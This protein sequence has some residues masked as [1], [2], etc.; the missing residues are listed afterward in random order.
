MAPAKLF[1]SNIYL[2]GKKAFLLVDIKQSCDIDTFWNLDIYFM[3]LLGLLLSLIL[4]HH[5]L[6]FPSKNLK[7]EPTTTLSSKNVNLFD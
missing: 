5:I 2:N 7:E 1:S 4:K 3:N 6:N